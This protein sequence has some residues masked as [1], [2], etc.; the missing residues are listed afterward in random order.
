MPPPIVFILNKPV[1]IGFDFLVNGTV[2][3]R[4]AIAEAPS[5]PAYS[6]SYSFCS[7]ATLVGLAAAAR[8]AASW[9]QLINPG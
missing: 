9:D 3:G 5:Y 7:T 2:L 4:E 1:S 8:L 6:G